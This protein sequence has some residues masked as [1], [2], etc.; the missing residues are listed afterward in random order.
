MMHFVANAN[1]HYLFKVVCLIKSFLKYH[2]ASRFW[3]FAMDEE[4][5]MNMRHFNFRGIEIFN[6][7]IF[8]VPQLLAVKD[9]RNTWEYSQTCKP[10]ALQYVMS[11]VENHDWVIWIDSDMM[12]FASAQNMVPSLN[13][14]VFVTPH[15]YTSLF[16]HFEKLVGYIN[17]GLLGFRKDHIGIAALAWWAERC[18]EWCGSTHE[19]NRFADQKYAESFKELFS[20]HVYEMNNL[21]VNAAPWNAIERNVYQED[22]SVYIDRE[23]LVLYHFQGLRIINSFI[24]DLYADER[25]RLPK[26]LRKL[27]YKPYAIALQDAIDDVLSIS[28]SY[29]YGFEDFNLKLILREIK[30]IL[31]GKS[32][33]FLC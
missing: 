2:S 22:N 19:K 4:T 21:G 13:I 20:S 14:S 23:P 16:A 25:I 24:F 15:R 3:F 9:F 31:L 5:E 32:N 26:S 7:R 12:F 28:N 8:D 30:K 33:L 1:R 27:I 11:K 17:A 29:R 10:F 6:A 18:L